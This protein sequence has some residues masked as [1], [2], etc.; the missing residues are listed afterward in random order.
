MVC[1]L[2]FVGFEESSLIGEGYFRRMFFVKIL[3]NDSV[4]EGLLKGSQRTLFF[5]RRELLRS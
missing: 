3:F 1:S 2:F 5:L 4:E